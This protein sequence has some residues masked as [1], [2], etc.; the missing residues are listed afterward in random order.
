MTTPLGSDHPMSPVPETAPTSLDDS[1]EPTGYNLG[2]APTYEQPPM[3]TPA[4]EVSSSPDLSTRD[5][6]LGLVLSLVGWATVFTGSAF[7]VPLL[8]AGVLK[9][10]SAVTKCRR[11]T[12]AGRKRALAG[13]VLGIVGIVV[14]LV[15]VLDFATG[16]TSIHMR[17]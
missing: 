6:T 11:G 16:S 14:M 9:S 8:C 13:V 12:A 10:A 7:A 2:L 3:P 5:A 17:R 15:L 4:Q 1:G